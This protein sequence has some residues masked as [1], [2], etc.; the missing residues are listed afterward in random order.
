MPVELFETYCQSFLDGSEGDLAYRV[1][2][3][4]SLRV[5]D[6]AVRLAAI[7]AVELD[8]LGVSAETAALAGLLHDAGRFE[9]F[10]RFQT[11]NDRVSVNHAALSVRV[12]RRENFLAHLSPA[13]QRLVLGAI[14]LHNRKIVRPPASTPL[15]YLARLLRDADKLDIYRVMLDYF[16]PGG[17]RPAFMTLDAKPHETAYTPEVLDD[18]L[19][20]RMVDYARLCWENDFKLLMLAWVHDLN[21][22]GAAQAFLERDL[23]GRVL[24]LLPDN[25]DV[26]KAGRI[27]ADTL[28]RRAERT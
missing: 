25:P 3:D 28:V 14:M 16:M 8:R 9:Q 2:L 15:G 1:K 12:I 10:R 13:V 24:S 27:L 21:L 26:R 22:P 4:H 11:F 7:H 17:D 23:V 6:E 18:V 19:A 20:G 5:R